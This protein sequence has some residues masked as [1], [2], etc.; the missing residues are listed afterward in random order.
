MSSQ[1][2]IQ[3]KLMAKVKEIYPEAYAKWNES[4]LTEGISYFTVMPYFQEK[5]RQSI[6]GKG[7]TEFVAWQNAAKNLPH[8]LQDT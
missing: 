7:L 1:E 4:T 8:K 5:H 6:L 3:A 2:I